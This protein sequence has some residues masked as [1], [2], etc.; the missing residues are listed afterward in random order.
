MLKISNLRVVTMIR[1]LITVNHSDYSEPN[2]F[3]TTY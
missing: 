1:K 3:S 2:T